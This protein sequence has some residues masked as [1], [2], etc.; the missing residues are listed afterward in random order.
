MSL[1]RSILW[2]Y[3]GQAS[4]LAIGLVASVVLAR[5]LSPRDFGL[6]ALAQSIVGLLG[7]M[8]AVGLPQFLIREQELTDLTLRAA[9]T[10]NL[11]V[12]VAIAVPFVV[13][14]LLVAPAMAP[15]LREV[16]LFIALAGVGSVVEFVPRSLLQRDMRFGPISSANVL[17]AVLSAIVAIPLARHGWGAVSIAAGLAAGK[18]SSSLLL[19]AAMPR[20]AVMWPT[21]RGLRAVLVY[22]AQMLSITGVSQG[23]TR[24]CDLVLARLQ[25]VAGLGT[26]A[27]ASQL[28]SQLYYLVYGLA[29][30]VLFA[31]L[32]EDFRRTGEIRETYLRSVAMLTGVLWPLS[33]GLAILARPVVRLVYGPAW[34]GSA[35]PLSL[36]MGAMAVNLAFAMNWELFVLRKETA[37]QARFEIARSVV[38]TVI[39]TFA[40]WWSVAAAAAARLVEALFTYALYAP[41]MPR[42]IGCTRRELRQMYLRSAGAT[43]CAVLPS[44]GL[45]LA[46]GFDPLTSPAEM[47]AAILGGAVLWAAAL[48]VLKH[49]LAAEGRHVIAVLLRRRAAPLP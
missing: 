46:N 20:G 43:A 37:R 42:M 40:C 23:A 21:T 48:I 15:G 29:T 33:I 2:S 4:T 31:K 12:Q 3:A 17:N 19:V 5:L 38:G 32:S 28:H 47:A 13:V 35:L 41:S 30:G 39:F 16:M 34:L 18:L 14:A 8:T 22:G 26:Y 44:L 25:G 10:A 36:L 24:A 7:L 11:L 9:Y 49:D 6:F 27:R 1:R 45:M